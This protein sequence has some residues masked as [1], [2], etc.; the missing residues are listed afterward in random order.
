MFGISLTFCLERICP[1]PL[2]IQY[3]G[4]ASTVES[5]ALLFGIAAFT[6]LSWF[7]YVTM[8]QIIVF[9]VATYRTENTLLLT[10]PPLLTAVG[11]MW[12]SVP[13]GDCYNE[14]GAVAPWSFLLFLIAYSVLRISLIR[15]RQLEHLKSRAAFVIWYSMMVRNALTIIGLSA[16]LIVMMALRI[17]LWLGL[18]ALP[19]FVLGSWL[20]RYSGSWTDMERI[21]DGR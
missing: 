15:I 18:L 14:A 12:A 3:C 21:Y 6:V 1:I 8:N 9:L 2:A 5:I 4:M 16:G 10:I 13:A 11:I 17:P 20:W 7:F 19:I